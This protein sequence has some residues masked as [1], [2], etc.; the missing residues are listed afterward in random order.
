MSNA[1]RST[2]HRRV[3]QA[4]HGV[5]PEP[6][7]IGASTPYGFQAHNLTAYGGLLP[8]ATMLE[9]LG[10]LQQIEET[11]TVKRQTHARHAGVPAHP[12]DG[13]GLLRGLFAAALPVPGRAH[14]ASCWPRG[15]QLQRS[16]SGETSL[17][18]PYGAAAKRGTR[19]GWICSRSCHAATRL[20]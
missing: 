9:K 6:N 1:N 10:F 20:I 16:L 12:G 11:L 7:K 3:N 8:V 18:A 5:I 13:A 17:P 15:R 4:V 2:R 14:L 19:A